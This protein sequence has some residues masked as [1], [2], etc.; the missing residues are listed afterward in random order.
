MTKKPDIINALLPA[1]IKSLLLSM[2]IS[3]AIF[4]VS[5][6]FNSLGLGLSI[7]QLGLASI[8]VP[9]LFVLFIPFIIEL[10]IITNTKYYFFE[11]RILKEFKF[12]VI[13]KQSVLYK[14][15]LNI[16]V[17]V[18]LWD[19][20]CNAGRIT[21]HTA[22][23]NV[24]DLTLKYLKPVDEIEKQIYSLIDRDKKEKNTSP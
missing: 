11:T 22:E 24:P 1:F 12:F 19:R 21:M 8:I 23:D 15:V 14:H 6:L 10:V 5:Y 20:I 9:F 16:T 18:N 4:V 3:F 13:K 7:L 2:V 17:T